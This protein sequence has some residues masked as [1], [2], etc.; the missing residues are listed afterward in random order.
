MVPKGLEIFIFSMSS[1]ILESGHY[2]LCKLTVHFVEEAL[3]SVIRSIVLLW[4]YVFLF[5]FSFLSLF[6]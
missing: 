4:Y 3:V 5:S 2:D 1:D 6:F